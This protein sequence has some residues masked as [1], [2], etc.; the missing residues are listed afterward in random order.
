MPSPHARTEFILDSR[1]AA[2]R[3]AGATS[4]ALTVS[5]C[6]SRIAR[7]TERCS[8]CGV[9]QSTAD[10][11]RGE[12][13]PRASYLCNACLDL[14]QTIRLRRSGPAGPLV[15]ERSLVV[16]GV[17]LVWSAYLANTSE[18]PSVLVS[19]RRE[20]QE[21]TRT[22]GLLLPG[23]V[24]PNEDHVRNLARTFSEE[25]GLDPERA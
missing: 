8:F 18:V 24:I 12:A 21:R 2:G 22:V 20:D 5:R 4:A 14:A 6:P 7:V 19:L 13:S 25:L 15:E 17:T 23:M 3:F 16:D 10:L 1:C 11:I 9:S